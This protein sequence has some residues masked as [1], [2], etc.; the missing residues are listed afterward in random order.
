MLDRPRRQNL[1]EL[2]MM[3]LFQIRRVVSRL[4]EDL[5]THSLTL[6][7]QIRLLSV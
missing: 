5:A 3:Y 6:A 1:D 7:L 4:R 2:S